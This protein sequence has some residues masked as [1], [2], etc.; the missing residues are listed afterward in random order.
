M[1]TKLLVAEGSLV[2]PWAVGL[3]ISLLVVRFENPILLFIES[4]RFFMWKLLRAGI[5]ATLLATGI[6]LIFCLVRRV[7]NLQYNRQLQFRLQILNMKMNINKILQSD[8]D[9]GVT[10][11]SLREEFMDKK[12]RRTFDKAWKEVVLN[13]RA[14][15]RVAKFGGGD[16]GI[17]AEEEVWQWQWRDAPIAGQRD[18]HRVRRVS[19]PRQ[20]YKQVK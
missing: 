17:G 14:D 5:L 7:R 15:Y 9:K 16:C 3:F 11:A 18:A 13:I 12:Q 10:V 20:P 6:H 1:Y 4:L 19:V 8:P 2:L